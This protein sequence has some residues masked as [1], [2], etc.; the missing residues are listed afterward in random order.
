MEEMKSRGY[1]PDTAT[2]FHDTDSE[3]KEN[4]L[5]NHSEKLAIAF[6]L[7]NIPPGLPIRVMKNLLHIANMVVTSSLLKSVSLLALVEDQL[8]Q[9]K[10]ALEF[11]LNFFLSSSWST[12]R[13]N[14]LGKC[15]EGL[16]DT[17]PAGCRARNRGYSGVGA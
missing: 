15:L 7:M 1:V 14:A 13:H 6:G 3:E 17:A 2:I 11:S 4:S 10:G 12:W 16:M 5:V 9:I 8:V